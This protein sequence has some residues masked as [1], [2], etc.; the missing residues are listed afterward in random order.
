L[1]QTI[2]DNQVDKEKKEQATNDLE[3][4]LNLAKEARQSYLQNRIHTAKEDGKSVL[5]W[6]YAENIMLPILEETPST[7]FFKTRRKIELVGIVNEEI[8]SEGSIQTNFVIDECFKIKKDANSIVSMLDFYL[9][10]K[11]VPG[12]SLI[13]YTDNCPGQNKNYFVLGYLI[14]LVKI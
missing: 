8:T 1:K 4:H 3:V 2:K 12:T 13:L 5:S 14:Y 10:G 6:D 9:K 7:F 11:I